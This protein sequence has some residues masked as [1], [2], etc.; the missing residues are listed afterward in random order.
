[1]E[2]G[3]GKGRNIR[4]KRKEEKVEEGGKEKLHSGCLQSVENRRKDYQLR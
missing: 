1:M 2:N 4:G 3:R